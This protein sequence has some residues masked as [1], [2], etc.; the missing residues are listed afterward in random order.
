MSFLV[1]LTIFSIHT[2]LSTGSYTYGIIHNATVK[3]PF[4]LPDDVHHT[5]GNQPS[6]NQCLC[7]AFNDSRVFLLT[8]TD[9]GFENFT[10]QFYYFLPMRDEL[11]Y[12]NNTNIYLMKNETFKEK[13]DCCNTTYL[14]EQLNSISTNKTHVFKEALRYLVFGDN[15]TIASMYKTKLIK[16]NKYTFE[17]V[18]ESTS[19]GFTTVGFDGKY[20]YLGLKGKMEVH[21]VIINSPITTVPLSGDLTSIRSRNNTKMLV[22]TATSVGYICE[23]QSEIFNNCIIIPELNQ[24]GKQL[25]ALDIVN[26]STFYAGW[27]DASQSVRLYMKDQNNKWSV[28]NSNF[29]D[30]TMVSDIVVDDCQRLWVVKAR[31]DKIHIYDQNKNS[32]NI[33]TTNSGLFNLLVMKNYTLVTSHESGPSGLHVTKPTLN[34]RPPR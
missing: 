33:F 8:C 7:Q 22:G 23:K 24:N 13:D 14:L 4:D 30:S 6:C 28:N 20:Y 12:R 10:C 19:T 32:P 18:Y 25:H 16:F 34:C 1:C 15:N 17:K 27:D 21:S 2:Y 11:R 9:N 31:T 5:L 26:D 3:I 29:I